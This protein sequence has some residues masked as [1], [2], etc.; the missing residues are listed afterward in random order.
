M[1]I[2]TVN[3]CKIGIVSSVSRS[4]NGIN[5]I[6]LNQMRFIII[7]PDICVK[8]IHIKCFIISSRYIV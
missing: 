8:R 1:G 7:F 5:T 4:F 3:Y 6:K 2:L